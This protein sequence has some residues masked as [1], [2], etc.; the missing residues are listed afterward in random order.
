MKHWKTL[1]ATALA[2]SFATAALAESIYVPNLS[3]RTG[4]FAATGIPLMNGQKDYFE[5]LNARDG[6]IGGVM[7]EFEECETGYSTEKGVECYEKTKGNAVVTQPWSTGITLQVLPKTNVDQIPILAPGYGFSPMADGKTFQWA[8]NAP[9]GYWDAADMLIS[10][11]NGLDGGLS[12]KKIAF[13][14]LDHPYGKEPIPLFEKKAAEM[15]FEFLPIPVGLKEMQNQSAQWLQI[16]RERPD[17]VIMWGWGAMNAGAITEAVKTKF[18]MSKFYGVWWSGHDADLA[19]VGADGAG[20]KSISWSVPKADAPVMA[21][22]KTHV[23][24]TGKTL[25]NPEEMAGVFYGRGVVMSMILAEAIRGAQAEFATGVVTPDQVRWGL[26]NL[27]LTEDR[28]TELG[29]AGMIPPFS[30][31]CADH[32]GHSGAWILE[33]DGAKFNKASDLLQA[34]VA[35]YT[36]LLE[37]SAAEYATANAPWPVNEAC[38]ATN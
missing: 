22:I 1:A 23:V 28:L 3:Y 15:G 30:T 21:D 17:Y 32:T 14:H 5:M 2:A 26:E 9:A 11:L 8:F 29:V 12:G 24:D 33:W 38:S 6:G 37:A 13:L 34:D 31:S 20:Y 16:R 25:S 10:H 19:L 4:P 7:I 35:G 36:E 27:N 18:D